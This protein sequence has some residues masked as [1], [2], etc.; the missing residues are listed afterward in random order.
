[1]IEH[2][3]YLKVHIITACMSYAVF[4]VASMAAVLFLIQ[5]NVLKNKWTGAIFNRLPSLSFLDKLNYRSIG[6]AF[7]ILTFSIFCAFLWSEKIHGIHWWAYNSRVVFFIV[8]WLIYAVILHMRL[9]AKMRGRKVA[10]LS[11]V[12]FFVIILSLFGTCP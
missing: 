4:F 6:L 10:L 11:V 3:L 8:I 12:A 1:M 9:S 7:P 2:N 5:N